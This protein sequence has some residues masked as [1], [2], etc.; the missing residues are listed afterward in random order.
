VANEVRE[1]L[2]LLSGLEVLTDDWRALADLV[3]QCP[4]EIDDPGLAAIARRQLA[5]R[6]RDGKVAEA[7]DAAD[8]ALSALA[9]TSFTFE[10]GL[11]THAHLMHENGLFGQLRTIVDNRDLTALTRWTRTEE[12]DDLAEFLDQTTA[13]VMAGRKNNVIHSSKR[14]AYLDRLKLVRTATLAVASFDD[15][16]DDPHTSYLLTRAQ[17]VAERLAGLWPNLRADL[18]NHPRLERQLTEHGLGAISTISEWGRHVH[19]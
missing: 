3:V 18:D 13:Q 8:E 14:R 6:H 19:H 15:G 4:Q 2:T 12:F 11:K 17:P 9:G 7:W 1:A 5:H 16:H 10:A